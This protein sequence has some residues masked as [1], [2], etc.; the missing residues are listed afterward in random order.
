MTIPESVTS[1]EEGAFI[2]CNQLSHVN[3]S[4]NIKSISYS[5]FYHTHIW[6]IHFDGTIEQWNAVKKS[7]FPAFN[8]SI[9]VICLDGTITD[10]L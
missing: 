7:V 1:I 2:Y 9:T 10:E 8:K 6:D 4:K 5:A 3:I